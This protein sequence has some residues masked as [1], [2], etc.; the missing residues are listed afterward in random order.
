MSMR[1]SDRELENMLTEVRKHSGT[2]AEKRT[3]LLFESIFDE[4]MTVRRQ[5]SAA[6]YFMRKEDKR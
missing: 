2:D 5:L 6:E 4:L 1:P 3:C